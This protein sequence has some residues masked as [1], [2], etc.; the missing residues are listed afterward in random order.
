MSTESEEELFRLGG[1]KTDGAAIKVT[2]DYSVDSAE[3]GD[4]SALP[5]YLVVDH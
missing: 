5:E 4:S 1:T 3:K 2:K